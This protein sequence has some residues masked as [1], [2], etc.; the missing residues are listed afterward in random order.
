MREIRLPYRVPIPFLGKV[1]GNTILNLSLYHQDFLIANLIER[2]DLSLLQQGIHM[3][4][5][6]LLANLTFLCQGNTLAMLQRLIK[7]S[8][9]GIVV[10]AK[11]H[12]TE[13]MSL[14]V[15]NL[16]FINSLKIQVARVTY[17]LVIM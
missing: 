4:P 12:P 5:D 14:P 8:C 6:T 11:D 7:V 1:L 3:F 16:S 2:I 13:P 10:L 15:L 17:P 9:V